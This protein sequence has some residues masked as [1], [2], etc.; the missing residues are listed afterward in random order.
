MLP[1]FLLAALSVLFT[2]PAAAQQQAVLT[3]TY[4]R[5][6]QEDGFI[7]Q[8][9]PGPLAGV[10]P[11]VEIA[12]VGVGVLTYIDNVAKAGEYCYRVGAY[13]KTG[14]SYSVMTTGSCG[15]IVILEAPSIPVLTLKISQASGIIP[16]EVSWEAPPKP[17]SKDWVGL[18]L[19]SAPNK[20]FLSD[21]WE[22]T[23]GK[24]K[25]T[26]TVTPPKNGEYD[27]RYLLNDS[28]TLSSRTY[29]F[30]VE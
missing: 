20:E 12:R 30:T 23:E 6:A 11:W 19:A 24:S 4:T 27:V 15:T 17:T 7:I 1:I 14:T 28:F 10:G 25:G 26:F 21:K 2:T 16:V 3:W 13:N 29:K 22:Y 9:R 5:V 18:F 8:R